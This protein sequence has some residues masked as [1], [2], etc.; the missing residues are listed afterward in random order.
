MVD[1][2]VSGKSVLKVLGALVVVVVFFLVVATFGQGPKESEGEGCTVSRAGGGG[3]LAAG[4]VPHGWGKNIET[5][6]KEAGVPSGIIAAQ[7][8]Q[9]SQWNPK[10][11]SA[12]G[13]RGL[14]QFMPDTWKKVMGDADPF[15]PKLSIKAQ[16]KYMGELMDGAAKVAK[17][18]GK[19]QVSLALAAYN[20]GPG[21][22]DQYRDIPP[23]EETQTYVK[24]ITA[25]AAKYQKN[26]GAGKDK[27]AK[28]AANV[29]TCGGDKAAGDSHSSGKDDLPWGKPRLPHCIISAGYTC[30]EGSVS[31]TGMYNYEC[32]DWGLWVVNR[33]FGVKDK[34]KLRFTNANF[35]P[36]GVKLGTAADTAAGTDWLQGWKA[37][38][39]P[40]GKTP[41]EGAIVFYG[42]HAGSAGDMGH[43]A[44]VRSYDGGDTFVE[45]GY[46]GN[47]EPDD[48]KYY[49]RSVK[50]SEV[51]MFLYM[52]DG[53]DK[54]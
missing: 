49:T 53:K 7:I 43:I 39:W 36:D 16:G 12:A 15:D 13:A 27:E 20:A 23:F 8:N 19:D 22:I 26:L 54:K 25:S 5:A 3:A 10:A 48:H 52:P 50:K 9:E 34:D 38:G 37:K 21:R 33:N 14:T 51:T 41:K 47:P 44:S 45:E 18:T 11:V 42:P 30:P 28:P 40:T 29:D 35:R 2:D 1:A 46:N 6:A 32:T 4:Q 31:V 24:N 17:E